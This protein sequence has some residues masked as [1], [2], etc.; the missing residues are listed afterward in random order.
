MAAPDLHLRLTPGV[1]DWLRDPTAAPP[2]GGPTVLSVVVPVHDHAG[3]V[4]EAELALA[5][6]PETGAPRV[7]VGLRF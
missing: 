6:D 5:F 2:D 3:P 4:G 7:T 1:V